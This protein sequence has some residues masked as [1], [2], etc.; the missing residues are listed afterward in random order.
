MAYSTSTGFRLRKNLYGLQTEGQQLK[1]RVANSTTLKL[2]DAVRI[3]TGGFLVRSAAGEAVLGILTG[4]IGATVNDVTGTNPFSLGGDITG[5]TLTEDDQI[6]TSATNQTRT[7]LYLVGEVTVDPAG[8]LLWYNDS[9]GTLA[10]TNIGQYFDV[11]SGSNQI[12]SA[13]AADTN[14]Q[15]ELIEID[16]DNDGDASKGLLRIAESQ[17][18]GG[19]DSGTSKIAA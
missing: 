10:R 16:P 14:G 6:V 13:S 11:L 2:G 18:G 19:I 8:I 4:F 5:L 3:N 1:V 12:D 15:F 17:I 9:D 7:E